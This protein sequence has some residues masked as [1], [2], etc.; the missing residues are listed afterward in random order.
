MSPNQIVFA[1]TM[2]AGG[3]RK[4]QAKTKK[5]KKST[6]GSIIVFEGPDYCG[7]STLI[8]NLQDQPSFKHSICIN[9]P[10]PNFRQFLYSKERF[11]L[12]F[13]L[14]DLKYNDGVKNSI[15]YYSLMTSRA[16]ALTAAIAWSIKGY[17]VFVNRSFPST[18]VYQSN[19][20]NSSSLLD[21]EYIYE[22]NMKLIND[23]AY[24]FKLEDYSVPAYMIFL[25]ISDKELLN[26]MKSRKL[27]NNMDPQSKKEVS[28]LNWAYKD[29]FGFL[30]SKSRFEI[31]ITSW[32]NDQILDIIKT[33]NYLQNIILESCDNNGR[34][35]S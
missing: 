9:E 31:K 20:Y 27:R 16:A 4:L 28:Y 33:T 14:E 13:G 1:Y 12:H 10:I 11:N 3:A 7:K 35:K 17:T 32:S 25:D 24:S 22:E 6:R 19:D 15:T 2:Y 30:K 5:V 18:L 23:L 34:Q 8:K 29:I 26:R 21:R